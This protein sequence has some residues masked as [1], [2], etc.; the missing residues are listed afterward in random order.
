[1]DWVRLDP[2]AISSSVYQADPTGDVTDPDALD[3]AISGRI[4]SG[5]FG[6]AQLAVVP[7]LPPTTPPGT[8]VHMLAL[9]CDVTASGLLWSFQSKSATLVITEEFLYS[10]DFRSI[11]KGVLTHGNL[12]VAIAVRAYHQHDREL[13]TYLG[14]A[15]TYFHIAV[16]LARFQSI[17]F[18]RMQ[19]LTDFERDTL[20][21][22]RVRD[23][24]TV[25][26]LWVDG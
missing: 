22:L 13:G 8:N 24:I 20:R 18:R 3:H 19:A 6:R 16:Q 11:F 9:K 1:M 12:K 17:L 2:S 25:S 26:M 21:R 10:W 14:H 5:A 4:E 23:K 7:P 15:Q